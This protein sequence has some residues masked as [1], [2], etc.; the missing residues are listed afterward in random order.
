MI[1]IL[2]GRASHRDRC[3]GPQLSA[4]CLDDAA[5]AVDADRGHE[6]RQVDTGAAERPEL[7]TAA[8]QRAGQTRG[9]E[10]PIAERRPSD[11]RL[12][13]IRLGTETARTEQ[14][15]EEGEGGV[16]RQVR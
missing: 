10:N 7:L 14:A 4:E 15:L 3:C 5:R 1:W 13:L 11:A 12:H 8:R 16:Q 2:K 6:D 9:I